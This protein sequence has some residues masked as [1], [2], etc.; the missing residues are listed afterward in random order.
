MKYYQLL[1]FFTKHVRIISL[2]NSLHLSFKKDVD[3]KKWYTE[4]AKEIT[5]D[6]NDDS[7]DNGIAKLALDNTDCIGWVRIENTKIDFPVMQTK[8]DPEFYLR[9]NFNK[10]HSMFIIFQLKRP[11]A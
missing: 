6:E 10:K 3:D 8:S 5:Y 2:L 4:T 1:H 7:T 9:R 11:L